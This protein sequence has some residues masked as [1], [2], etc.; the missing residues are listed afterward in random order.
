MHLLRE[1]QW[2]GVGGMIVE[3]ETDGSALL[4]IYIEL[5][6]YTKMVD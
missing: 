2:A 4:H 3:L 5:K 1:P 6:S